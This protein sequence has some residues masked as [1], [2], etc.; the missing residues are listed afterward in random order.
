MKTT[1]KVNNRLTMLSEISNDSTF[2]ILEYENLSGV[3]SVESTISINRLQ[4]CGV[5]LKQIR[6]VLD[7]SAV[8]LQSGVLNFMKGNISIKS[9]IDTAPKF[10]RMIFKNNNVDES[11]IKPILKG[12]GEIFLEPSIEYFTL[13]ELEDDEIVIDDSIFYACEEDVQIYKVIKKIYNEAE[14]EV[15]QLRLKGNGIV[16]LKIPV[17]EE[18]ILRYKLYK[19]KLIVNG[20]LVV[21]KYGNVNFSIEKSGNTLIGSVIGD[22]DEISVYSGIGEVWLLPTKSIYNNI[23]NLNRDEIYSDDFDYEEEDE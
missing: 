7:D 17:P 6:V 5:T 20:D 19:E 15:L 18:E 2:Q 3:S 16:V 1:V 4:E 9:N 12:N 22:E 23:D 11:M 13:L 10:T 21:L 8:K 14:E